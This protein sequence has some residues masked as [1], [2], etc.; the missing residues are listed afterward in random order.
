[1]KNDWMSSFKAIPIEWLL[2]KDNPPVKYF[3]MRD[4]LD[5]KSTDSEL[6]EAR[7]KII[8]YKVTQRIL[9]RQ[10]PDGSWESKNQPYLPKY[11]SSYWQVMFLAMFG[12][13]HTNQQ[14]ERAVDHILK[15]QYREGGFVEFMEEGAKREYEY[16][17]KRDLKHKKTYPPVEEWVNARIREMELSCL[18]GNM[19]LALIRL[20]YS[21]HSVVRNA[22]KWLVEIQNT[23]GGWL[24][25]YWGAHKDDKHG[26]FMGTI[27][28]LDAFSEAPKKLLN[29]S[30]KRAI[31]HGAE[32][33]L[34]HRL[35]KAD[36]HDFRPIKRQWL[37][38]TFPEFFYDIL[39][40]L[41]VVTKLGYAQDDRIDDALGV[42]MSKRL[43]TGE[44]PVERDYAGTMYGVIERKGRA[45]KWIT[46]EV[47]RVLKR[48]IQTRG[49]LELT[50]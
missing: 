9:D 41:S 17:S 11:K 5:Y 49:H 20:G 22:L 29:A 1:V 50:K 38:L 25:P 35:Y 19:A 4:L 36:H 31:K 2:G 16:L 7:E 47:L 13:E 21:D 32:F 34:M 12:L 23:D 14:V 26:C 46:L 18:T 30:A 37:V 10:D 39:R 40:G 27:T 42:I 6:L 48:V 28:P 45:S 15:F 43:S 8:E 44:W 24:C 3:T 33:L